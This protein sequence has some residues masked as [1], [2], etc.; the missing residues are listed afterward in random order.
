MIRDPARRRDVVL[1]VV[2]TSVATVAALALGHG[3]SWPAALVFFAMTLGSLNVIRARDRAA[4][5]QIGSFDRFRDWLT[6]AEF[7]L[8]GLTLLASPFIP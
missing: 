7:G 3:K 6:L 2:A 1:A 8:A 4:R 5:G